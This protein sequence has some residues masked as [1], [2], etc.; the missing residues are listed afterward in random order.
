[1]PG[2]QA[3]A[4]AS[5]TSNP[6]GTVFGSAWKSC[7]R[8]GA[9]KVQAANW[10]SFTKMTSP[11]TVRAQGTVSTI[12]SVAAR[13]RFELGPARAERVGWRD[14]VSEEGHAP[15]LMHVHPMHKQTMHM[16]SM[17]VQ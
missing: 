14:S 5:K 8:N 11:S 16:H 12:F 7:S 6:R 10:A 1:M 13:T 3:P 17:Q 4:L 9:M 2:G 15:I